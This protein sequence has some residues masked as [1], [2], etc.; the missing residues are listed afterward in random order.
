MIDA[1][2]RAEQ[3]AAR[4]GHARADGEDRGVDPRHRDAHG[5]GHDAILRGGA[6]PDAVGAVFEEQPEGADDGGREPR[7]QH[8]VPRV[9]EVEQR[10]LAGEGLLNLARHGAKLPQRVVLH[11]Q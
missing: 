9:F 2:E 10:E 7:D 3:H 11:D 6:D 1:D 5:L 4:G 8:P